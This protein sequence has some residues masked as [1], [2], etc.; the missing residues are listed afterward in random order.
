MYVMQ[1]VSNGAVIIVTN[2]GAEIPD[3]PVPVLFV[4]DVREAM[5]LSAK[6]FYKNVVDKMDIIGVTGTNGK[7]TCTYIMRHLVGKRVGVVGTLGAYVGDQKL[8]CNLTT[9]DPIQLHEI[10]YKMYNMGVR[11]VAMEVS[12]HAIHYRKVA[13]INFRVGMFTNLTQD[14]LDFFGT[15]ED[16]AKT[17]VD[18]MLGDRVQSAV[19]NADDKYGQ[20]ILTARKDAVAY[21]INDTS[22]L[23]IGQNGSSFHL[24]RHRFDLQ[25]AGRF[26]VSNALACVTAARAIGISWRKIKK[27]LA[28]VQPVEG[29]FNILQHPRGFNIVI[30][31]AHTPDGLEKVLSTAREICGGNKLIS[32]FGCG[33]NRDKGK[34]EIMGAISGKLADFT[35]VTS[36]NP[37]DEAPLAIMY[38]IEAGIKSSDNVNYQLVEDRMEATY[39]ALDMAT[40]G[41]VVVLAGKGAETTQEI[42]GVFTPYIDAEIVKDYIAKVN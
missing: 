37:R 23:E 4:D 5:A 25:L 18:Y 3:I 13:G 39:F 27:R 26:N 31:Y 15:M 21:S 36:D 2:R 8:E 6:R 41:D 30:D 40:A 24:G 1:A 29:R 16:Y 38:Q 12:A 42:A 11:T 9:P 34:R 20:E 35:V 32:V 22:Y 14:H 17:K 19:V 33:G 7:T 28:T 10:F